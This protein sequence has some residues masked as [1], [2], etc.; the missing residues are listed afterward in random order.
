MKS[1][2]TTAQQGRQ[3]AAQHVTNLWEIAIKFPLST[4]LDFGVHDESKPPCTIS[5]SE[6]TSNKN[7]ENIECFFCISSFMPRIV[8]ATT[9][10]ANNFGTTPS[11]FLHCE[12]Q[13]HYLLCH[14]GIVGTWRII[15]FSKWLVTVLS[16]LSKSPRPGVV[17]PLPNGF[18][19]A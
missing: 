5:V 7:P 11:S 9:R 1:K 10:W 19:M 17:G 2:C 18:V 16:K 14:F 12:P 8:C 13:V 4:H 3:F 6:K 15:P